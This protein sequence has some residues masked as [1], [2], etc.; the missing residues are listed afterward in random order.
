MTEARHA[1]WADV[2]FRPYL[3]EITRRT[4][5]AVRLLGEAPELPRD[6]PLIIV[7]NHGTWW[8]GFFIYLL[9][10]VVLHRRLYIMM[11]EEQLR[12][13][14]FFRRLGAFGIE[15][16][17]PRSVRA[18][19]SYSA[20][21]LM[22]ASNCLCVFPQGSMRRL[23]DRPLGFKRG[24]ESVLSMH[25]RA[26]CILPVAIACEFLGERRPEA[27]FLADRHYRM[28]G[29]GFPGI[30]W[31]EGVQADQMGRLQ[32]MISAGDKGRI[33]AGRAKR[34]HSG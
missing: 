30:E 17:H 2:V 33:L 25:G 12:R 34:R 7:A 5:E 21:V 9:N 6:V 4:F 23:H 28:D 19:L 32:S 8:D 14:R 1:A 22:D 15:R 3:R 13:Y 31:L 16:G 29:A 20:E 26:A 24:L 27:F 10:T 18:S 11:L